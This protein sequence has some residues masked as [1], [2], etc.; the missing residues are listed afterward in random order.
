MK[1]RKVYGVGIYEKGEYP[2]MENGKLTDEYVCWRHMLQRCYSPRYHVKRPTYIGCAVCDPWLYFQTFA[3]WYNSNYY[4]IPLLGKSHIDK[5]IL[6]KGNKIY[7]PDNCVFVPEVINNLFTKSNATRG[8]Y[9]IGVD[10][11]KRDK[12]YRAMISYGDG[13]SHHLGYFTTPEK[14]FNAYKTA[15]ENHIKKVAN[16]YR[17]LIP[18]KLYEAMLAYTVD[19]ND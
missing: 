19:I 11:Y 4:E 17:A 6:V 2:V 3:K 12:K 14:A 10:Y 8:K 16:D 7:S 15:K 9:P 13:K 5:D 18:V 1:S